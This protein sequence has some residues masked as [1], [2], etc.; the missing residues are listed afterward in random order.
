MYSKEKSVIMTGTFTDTY[1]SGLLN[2]MGRWYKPWFYKHVETF[3][4]KGQGI[5]YI[6]TVD[7]LFRHNKPFY[8]LTHIWLPFGNTAIF[9]YLFGWLLPFNFGLL[10]SW[11][12]YSWIID[13][14]LVISTGFKSH[15]K[16]HPLFC[17]KH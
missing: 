16:H 1:E 17:L 11:I 14:C 10:K 2:R 15:L 8:W 12:F 6:P 13:L 7:F 3:F 4:E 5:E 9:R